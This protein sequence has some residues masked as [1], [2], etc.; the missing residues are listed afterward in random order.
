MRSIDATLDELDRLSIAELRSRFAEVLRY[1]SNSRNRQFLVRKIVWGLQVKEQGDISEAARQ[2]AEALADDRALH[3]RLC[4][5]KP[6]KSNIFQA[7]RLARRQEDRLPAPGTIL[8]RTY[9]GKPI[10]VLVLTNGFE[11]QGQTFASLSAVARA[12]TG[13]RWNGFLFFGLGKAA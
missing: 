4:K 9:Q 12:V 2:R 3:H 7:A 1:R 11:W 5:P 8:V 13:T 10:R 6:A